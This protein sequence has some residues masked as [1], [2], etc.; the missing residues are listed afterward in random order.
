MRPVT[1]QPGAFA[2]E[3]EV[4]QHDGPGAWHF[5]SLPD[6]VADEI[7]DRWGRQAGGFG[8]V[9]VDVTIGAT[10]WSTSLFPDSRRRTYVLPVKKAVRTAEDLGDG[11]LARVE[12]VVRAAAP[13]EADG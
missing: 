9:K 13:G 11:S 2:F 4:W 1:Q 8:S 10:R 5:L 7:D 3:A 12:L 6:P